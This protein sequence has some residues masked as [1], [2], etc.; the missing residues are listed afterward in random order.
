MR[1]RSYE[2]EADVARLQRFNA[3]SI[4][5]TGGCGFLHPGDIAH[6]LFNGNKHF[7][8]A[9]L[10]TI[11]EDESG[12]AAWVL[13]QPTYRAYDIQVRHDLRGGPL[14]LPVPRGAQGEAHRPARPG[15]QVH[16]TRLPGARALPARPGGAPVHLDRCFPVAA[17]A[18]EPAAQHGVGRHLEPVG[19]ARAPG[20]QDRGLARPRFVLDPP[21]LHQPRLG[22]APGPL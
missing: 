6:H 15:T 12:V 11:W 19:D 13:A 16:R 21:R 22:L 8:P 5:A 14:H 7:D 9:D 3:E 1:R 2:G 17:Q 4:A 20:S 10:T 18:P